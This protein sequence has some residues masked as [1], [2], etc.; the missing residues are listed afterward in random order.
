[1][2]T[3]AKPAAQPAATKTETVLDQTIAATS[4][5][6]ASTRAKAAAFLGCDPKKISDVL[7]GVWTVTKGE[8]VL[9]DQELIVGMALVARYELD[10]FAREIYV[11]RGKKGLMVILGIDGWIRV[12][13]RTEHYDGFEQEEEFEDGKLVSV[14]TRIF[15]T[16]HSHPAAYTARMSEYLKLGGFVANTC[17]MHML[18]IFSLK[19]AARRFVPLG[20][21]VT[22]DE[23]RWMGQADGPV[24]NSLDEVTERIQGDAK[25]HPESFVAQQAALREAAGISK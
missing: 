20:G 3:D 24:A 2:S 6:A 18:G 23:A 12:L 11:T 22:E 9:T 17:P 4:A 25:L 15:S 8:P 16:K 1:M 5:R 14:T 19:H 7:R 13:D 10:P 21:C